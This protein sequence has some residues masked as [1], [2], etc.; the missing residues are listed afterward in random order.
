M[1]S[2][3]DPSDESAY[4]T[5]FRARQRGLPLTATHRRLLD[6]Q[7]RGLTIRELARV[8]GSTADGVR[9]QLRQVYAR[10]DVR[11]AAHAVRAGFED[12]LL[13]VGGT[14]DDAWFTPP[15]R[16]PACVDATG[17]DPRDA[18][19][20]LL[21]ALRS[22]EREVARLW[23]RVRD[24]PTGADVD[25]LR[26]SRDALRAGFAALQR[27]VEQRDEPPGRRAADR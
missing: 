5:Q 21:A 17:H 7:S 2:A 19:Q 14:T 20:L 3:D 27:A 15:R 10:L 4:T 9:Y 24:G 25:E 13:E 12:A 11:N 26:R 22:V 16:A 6:A 8:I 23:W 18:E 1:T